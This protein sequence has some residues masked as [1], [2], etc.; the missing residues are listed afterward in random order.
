[1]PWELDLRIPTALVLGAEG[2]G[3]SRALLQMS[4]QLFKI[5]QIGSTD[6]FNVSVSA[7]IL[8]YESMRQRLG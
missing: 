6:S 7:G 5:P 3:V 4:D 8:L 1:M 2:P